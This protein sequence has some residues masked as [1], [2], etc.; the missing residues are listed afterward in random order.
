MTINHRQAFLGVLFG[1]FLL[2]SQAALASSWSSSASVCQ[3]GVD[4]A[5][6][7]TFDVA[8]FKFSTGSTGQIKT[9]CHVTNPVDSA[10]PTWNTLT[11]GYLDPDGTGINYQV[12]A[13]LVRVNKSTGVTGT[14]KVFDSSAFAATGATSKSVTFTHTFDFTN[15]AY[16]VT[17]IV[18]RADTAQDP[19]VWYA[20]LH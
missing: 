12:D 9:R 13:Q 19:A 17:L 4:S 14:I 18:T 2:I 7:Y 10:V 16:F 15:F 8:S 20:Q 5:G 11:V 3:P 1:G 6:L